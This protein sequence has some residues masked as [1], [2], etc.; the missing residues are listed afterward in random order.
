MF[1][2]S[3]YLPLFLLWDLEQQSSGQECGLLYVEIQCALDSGLSQS[4]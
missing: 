2:L 4:H 3:F 1:Q